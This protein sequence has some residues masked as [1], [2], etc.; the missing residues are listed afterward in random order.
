MLP[1]GLT[2]LFKFDKEEPLERLEIT[3]CNLGRV[4]YTFVEGAFTF[5]NISNN[6]ITVD[7]KKVMDLEAK[8]VTLQNNVVEALENGGKLV[9][10]VKNNLLIENNTFENYQN[11]T[12]FDILDLKFSQSLEQVK[13]TNSNLG[14]I[15]S[16]FM[17]D[18]KVRNFEMSSNTL[19]LDNRNILKFSVVKQFNFTNNLVE[20]VITEALDLTVFGVVLIINNTFEHLQTQSF[21]GIHPAEEAGEQSL[22]SAAKLVFINNR[23]G[24]YEREFL[25]LK[26]DW[27]D[28][29]LELGDI[30]LKVDCDCSLDHLFDQF[31]TSQTKNKW[32]QSLYCAGDGSAELIANFIE[33]NCHQDETFLIIII[34]S[35]VAGSLLIIVI[36]F[37]II[38]RNMKERMTREAIRK[39]VVPAFSLHHSTVESEMLRCCNQIC[40]EIF[41]NFRPRASFI[42]RRVFPSISPPLSILGILAIFVQNAAD[43]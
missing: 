15:K 4:N 1:G 2:S 26:Q 22:E 37:I 41:Y 30:N 32:T 25:T 42:S 34:V 31:Q 17:F 20:D 6:I 35:C 19:T 16:N 27:S 12:D 28:W 3:E 5:V 13:I 24:S 38:K 29:E 11:E 10:K 9:L 39:F 40:I 33:E 43:V 23:I 8:N 18:I 21:E 14:R 7:Q 36:M